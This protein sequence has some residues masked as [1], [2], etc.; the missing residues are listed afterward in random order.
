[1]IFHGLEPDWIEAEMDDD[2]EFIRDVIGQRI[3]TMI[4]EEVSSKT[5]IFNQF[6]YKKNYNAALNTLIKYNISNCSVVLQET[7]ALLI[8]TD[9]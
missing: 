6:N 9:T 1:M 2:P 3:R 8:A 7:L 4:R 5:F